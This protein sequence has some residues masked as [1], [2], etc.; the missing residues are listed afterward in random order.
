MKGSS[1]L[2]W[3]GLLLLVLL[4]AAVAM[5]EG[6]EVAPSGFKSAVANK[7][8]FVFFSM[9]GCKHCQDMQNAW[10]ETMSSNPM[11]KDHMTQ[12]KTPKD[13]PSELEQIL[14]EYK[15][16]SYPTLLLLDNGKIADTYNGG[17][18]T[19]DLTAYMNTQFGK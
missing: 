15:I 7:K 6:F 3:Y 9:D 16:T 12:L 11:F 5:R 8:V 4:C 19:T 13:V 17:R 14:K 1:V 18:T 10:N 2:P